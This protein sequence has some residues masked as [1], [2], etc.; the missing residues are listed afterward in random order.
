MPTQVRPPNPSSPPFPPPGAALSWPRRACTRAIILSR[1]TVMVFPSRAMMASRRAYSRASRLNPASLSAAPRS[2]RSFFQNSGSAIALRATAFRVFFLLLPPAVS[3]FM[4]SPR[5]GL[6][7]RAQGVCP[8]PH[9]FGH[10]CSL[11][12]LQEL[13][14]VAKCV[15]APAACFRDASHHE[16]PIQPRR[17][18][19]EDRG[20]PLCD[21]V[22]LR[23]E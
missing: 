19:G 8:P 7:R 22:G 17:V 2:L 9:A 18:P 21:V 1:S 20:A 6:G 13:L 10:R 4:S 3:F 23:S 5:R 16:V 11:I 14:V 12:R 15:V